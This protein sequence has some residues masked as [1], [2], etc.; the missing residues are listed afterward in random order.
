[1]PVSYNPE[2]KNSKFDQKK[3][4]WFIGVGI[5]LGGI[6]SLFIRGF[7][8]QPILIESKA[9]EPTLKFGETHMLQKWKKNFLI[10]DIVLCERET[11]VII[12][13]IVG[14]PGDLIAIQDK[15]LIRNGDPIP[16]NLYP[17]QWIDDRPPLPTEL[18]TRDQ[19]PELRVPDNQ[20]FLLGDNRDYSMDSRILG[21]LP[22]ECLLGTFSEGN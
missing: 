14:K 13:R 6:L 5:V 9:M 21:T 11:G 19:M 12:S 22:R 17:A 4:L 2:R 15:T 7:I 10:G 16:K 3:L 20:F 1:M 8:Y 18:T